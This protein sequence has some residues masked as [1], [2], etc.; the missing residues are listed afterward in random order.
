MSTEGLLQLRNSKILIIGLGLMGGSLALALKG[1]CAKVIG[2]D[3]DPESLKIAMEQHIVDDAVDQIG[4]FISEVDCI[5]LATPVNLIKQYLGEMKDLIVGSKSYILFDIGSTKKEITDLM[6]SLPDN[7]DPVGCHPICG[8]ENL[9]IRSAE[10]TLYFGAPFLIT[11]LERTTE[12][13]MSFINQIVEVLGA[14]RSFVDAETH[15]AAL[16]NVSHLPY[17]ISSA[18]VM[19]SPKPISPYI[20]PGFR[21]SSRLAGTSS[22]MMLS[23]IQSN[24]ENILKNLENFTDEINFLTSVIAENDT[25]GLKQYLDSSRENYRGLLGAE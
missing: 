17:L 12:N 22:S 10:R 20:G 11:K 4:S 1:K 8:K 7:I 14:K 2:L 18:L 5:V 16:A 19:A 9:S 6:T 13:A 3:I 15:D 23:I 25:E 21:S 24:R